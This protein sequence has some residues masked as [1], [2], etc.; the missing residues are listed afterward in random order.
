MSNLF[1]ALLIAQT[2]IWCSVV[3]T[4]IC[5]F[6]DCIAYFIH[7]D[8][9]LGINKFESFHQGLWIIIYIGFGIGGVG[10]LCLYISLYL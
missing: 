9:Y 8:G 2:L 5:L 4:G 3:I 10:L 6:C 1:I 7:S